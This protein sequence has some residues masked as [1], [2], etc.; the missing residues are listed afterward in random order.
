LRDNLEDGVHWGFSW[1]KGGGGVE[2]VVAL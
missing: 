1:G 2:D